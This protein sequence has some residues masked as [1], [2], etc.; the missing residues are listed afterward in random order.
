M[1]S[2]LHSRRAALEIA[3]AGALGAAAR[4][5]VAATQLDELELD[6]GRVEPDW[7][8][9]RVEIVVERRKKTGEGVTKLD[10]SPGSNAALTALSFFGLFALGGSFGVGQ[11]RE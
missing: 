6:R 3:A 7:G 9:G 2:T 4:P 10:G 11:K 8:R 5:A 1:D